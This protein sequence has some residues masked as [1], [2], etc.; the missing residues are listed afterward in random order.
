MEQ[1][2]IQ[3]K[4]VEAR[5]KRMGR[6]T[7][8]AKQD[9]AWVQKR[10]QKGIS[11]IPSPPAPVHLPASSAFPA[12]AATAAAALVHDVHVSAVTDVNVDFFPS[13]PF[14]PA[15]ERLGRHRYAPVLS[16]DRR[17]CRFSKSIQE[18]VLLLASSFDKNELIE[19]W[20]LRY[21]SNCNRL[22]CRD[23]GADRNM[24]SRTLWLL[25][26]PRNEPI[27][28]LQPQSS[29]SRCSVLSKAPVRRIAYKLDGPSY[30][31]RGQRSTQTPTQAPACATI[32]ITETKV[33][34]NPH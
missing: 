31:C 28:V 32:P 3:K 2:V 1:A 4:P 22:W 24:L 34:T 19:S 5:G 17:V 8:R 15:S 29:P 21:C 33:G 25:S 16:A 11:T 20:G 14:V 10:I 23:H 12:A 7:R 27:P 9:A 18:R 26:Q 30:L 13:V 6:I